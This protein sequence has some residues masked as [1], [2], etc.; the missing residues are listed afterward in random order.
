MIK[1]LLISQNSFNFKM[2]DKLSTE[3][4]FSC[5][6]SKYPEHAME[7]IN[8]GQIDLIISSM[9]FEDTSCEALIKSL[10]QGMYRD[11]PVVV[12]SSTDD[13][14]LKNS[15]F[16]LGIID[17]ILY[18]DFLD[19]LR[20]YVAKIEMLKKLKI[21][22]SERS[23]AILD[24]D[25]LETTRMSHMLRRLGPIDIDVYSEPKELLAS[26]RKYDIYLI[27]MILPGVSGERVIIKLRQEHPFSVIIAISAVHNEKVIYNVLNSGADDY[28]LKPVKEEDFSARVKANLRTFMLLEEIK[29]KNEELTRL[30]QTDML[31]GLYNREFIYERLDEEHYKFIRYDND[32]SVIMM[33]LDHFKTINDRYGH[34][35]GD[36]V[37]IAI[38]KLLREHIRKSDVA[39]RFGGE[40]FLIALPNTPLAEGSI[41]AN[42]LRNLVEEM[43]FEEM[44]MTVT[45]SFGVAH[46]GARPVDLLREADTK[47]YLAKEN[48]R[49]RVES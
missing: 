20:T 18:E 44:D 15:L 43:K 41:L 4:G 12:L 37:L 2:I 23:F 31:T 10:N 8:S 29:A 27:D 24:D 5:V 13:A 47:L 49:N 6:F 38:G 11:I 34:L 42:K 33:D 35:I 40:E 7:I 45:A 46:G 39:G 16:E 9:Y 36:K 48:G 19:S 17:F 26:K 32:I 3:L 14:S 30:V 22:M 21:I 28:I 25:F 1:I